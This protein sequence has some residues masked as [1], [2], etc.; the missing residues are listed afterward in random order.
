MRVRVLL[1]LLAAMLL[2]ASCGDLAV[3]PSPPPGGEGA[4]SGQAPSVMLNRSQIEL[5]VG[6]EALLFASVTPLDAPESERRVSFASDTDCVS[7]NSRGHIRALSRG[8][9]TVSATLPNGVSATCAV[10]VTEVEHT[11]EGE[12]G[13]RPQAVTLSA[14]RLSLAVGE[15]VLLTGKIEP[16]EAENRALSFVNSNTR[17]IMLENHEENIDSSFTSS[18]TSGDTPDGARE[19]VA[20]GAGR[21]VI[22]V[23]AEDG[24]ASAVCEV[25]VAER[26]TALTFPAGGVRLFPGQTLSLPAFLTPDNLPNLRA[27]YSSSA[28][29]VAT[30]DSSGTITALAPG[31]ATITA[32]SGG[33]SASLAVTVTEP[34]EWELCALALPREQACG[35]TLVVGE[36]LAL[37]PT[38]TPAGCGEEIVYNSSDPTVASFLPGCSVATALSPGEA[39]LT[40]SSA[41]GSVTASVPLKVEGD[42]ARAVYLD[43]DELTLFSGETVALEGVLAGAAREG[44]TLTFLSTRPQVASVDAAGAV[45]GA[46]GGSAIVAA[47]ASPSGRAAVCRVTVL[48]IPVT[49]VS[50]DRAAI[51]LRTGERALLTATVEPP[52]ASENGVVFYSSNLAVATVSSDGT[53][54][55][56]APGE[57]TITARTV[58]GGHSATCTV[59]VQ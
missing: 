10:R 47:V 54:E 7:V 57:A 31:A 16:A 14:A 5:R 9:A 48:T 35:A 50:L 30:V 33:V 52:G 27:V 39:T 12:A 51:V 20:V 25:V 38:V 19:V 45:T 4:A 56:L 58:D 53:V 2:L 11:V 29:S 1:L 24:G 28:R 21:A 34:G 6:E 40:A 32:S 46:G 44:E 17:V 18:I 42:G 43:R 37:L 13:A 23:T 41:D 15:R 22:T 26:I 36:S 3:V 8:E 55:A 59:L 49:G